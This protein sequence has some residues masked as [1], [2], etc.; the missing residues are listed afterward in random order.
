M[1]LIES[2]PNNRMHLT[3][4]SGLR[5]PPPAGDAERWASPMK[6]LAVFFGL[7][8]A[9][10]ATA[11][12]AAGA[13]E[14]RRGSKPVCWPL[15]FSGVVLGITTDGEVQRILGKGAYR[16]DQGDAGGR[17]F[18]NAKH[19]A[20]LHVVSFTDAIVGEVVLTHGVDPAIQAGELKVATSPFFDPDYGFGNMHALWLGSTKAEVLE[21]LGPPEG[22]QARNEWRYSSGCACELPEYFTISF[23]KRR[24]YQV[25]F[26]APPG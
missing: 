17:Y 5:P 13:E 20:T 12:V 11:T 26:S 6:Q 22:D 23:R 24:I 3:G 25:I 2:A 19:T 16:P 9:L 18:V 8:A 14:S 21:N 4:Y 7:L 15:H 10:A 1:S